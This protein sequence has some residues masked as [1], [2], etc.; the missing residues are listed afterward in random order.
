[1][2]EDVYMSGHRRTAWNYPINAFLPMALNPQHATHTLAR[3]PHHI[4]AIVPQAAGAIAQ[5]SFP[6]SALLLIMAKAM[7]SLVVE[8]V[9]AG[10]GSN[11]SS[12]R[13]RRGESQAFVPGCSCPSCR[14]AAAAATP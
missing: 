8:M 14:A 13:N 6:H 2:A 4:S 1:M 7:N 11:S 5:G 9:M 10:D 12:S 3:L